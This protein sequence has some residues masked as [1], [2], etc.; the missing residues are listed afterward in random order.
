MS[1][2][3]A[4]AFLILLYVSHELTYDRHHSKHKLVYRLI[5][6]IR[7]NDKVIKFSSNPYLLADEL[8]INFPE[9]EATSRMLSKQ[10]NEGIFIKVNNEFIPE[11][12][13]IKCTDKGI[14][15]ILDIPLVYGSKEQIFKE[16][17]CV[18]SE[19]MA[20]KINQRRISCW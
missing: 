16:K 5:T 19:D 15:D 11:T 20:K 7:R 12:K 14:F 18:I 13:E 4:A 10:S 1:V 17:A 2:G 3:L 9:V 6:E 8:K